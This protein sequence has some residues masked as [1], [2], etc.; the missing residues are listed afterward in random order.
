MVG[1]LGAGEAECEA[2]RIERQHRRVPLVPVRDQPVVDLAVP[3]LEV[4][5]HR[6]LARLTGLLGT[7]GGLSRW[8]KPAKVKA[9]RVRFGL[10]KQ[11]R[12]SLAYRAP[13]VPALR[14]DR[15]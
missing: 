4:G 8:F 2:L 7:G 3:L 15:W 12:Q 11:Y 9:R 6:F 1:K 10:A 14:S 13:Y 5:A